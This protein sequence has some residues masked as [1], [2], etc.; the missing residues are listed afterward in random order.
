MSGL[1][2]IPTDPDY[3]EFEELVTFIDS[4]PVDDSGNQDGTR[5]DTQLLS[6][7]PIILG[8]Q[9]RILHCQ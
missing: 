1:G 4:V 3:W 2:S 8:T 5:M 6:T 9:P 7:A